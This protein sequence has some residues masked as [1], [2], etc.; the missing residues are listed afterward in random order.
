MGLQTLHCPRIVGV[1]QALSGNVQGLLD[2]NSQ[3]PDQPLMS[4]AKP[5]ARCN[6]GSSSSAASSSSSNGAQ[7]LARTLSCTRRPLLWETPANTAV[8]LSGKLRVGMGAP[9]GSNCDSNAFESVLVKRRTFTYKLVRITCANCDA[10]YKSNP[11]QSWPGLQPIA[12]L[13]TF[14]LG[15]TITLHALL[16]NVL[17]MAGE[18]L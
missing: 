7:L 9:F 11:P 5:R 6:A 13:C 1:G 17:P 16:R 12:A 15:T 2:P 4:F 10:S 8:T 3:C 14:S 18:R